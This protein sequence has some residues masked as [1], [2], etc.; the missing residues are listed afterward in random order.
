MPTRRIIHDWFHV[1]ALGFR[2]VVDPLMR[3]ADVDEEPVVGVE[4]QPVK[5]WNDEKSK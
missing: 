5:V 1:V 2:L 4:S 3:P